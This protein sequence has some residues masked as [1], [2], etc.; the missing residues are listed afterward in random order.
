MELSWRIMCCHGQFSTPNEVTYYS[1]Y[2]WLQKRSRSCIAES[3]NMFWWD[4]YSILITAEYFSVTGSFSNC[5]RTNPNLI[6]FTTKLERPPWNEMP[7]VMEIVIVMEK[8]YFLSGATLFRICAYSRELLLS[9]L[10]HCLSFQ[11]LEPLKQFWHALHHFLSGVCIPV[12]VL[13]VSLKTADGGFVVWHEF[14]HVSSIVEC[15]VSSGGRGGLL[16]GPP[17]GSE[18]GHTGG[19]GWCR[20]VSVCVVTPSW[21]PGGTVPMCVCGRSV[22]RGHLH[23][24]FN[25]IN[26]NYQLNMS[27]HFCDEQKF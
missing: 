14:P 7:C 13:N 26:I 19:S 16:G 22:K 8:N 25:L 4:E 21:H 15:Q 17:V 9:L 5:F 20:V 12:H 18:H 2:C 6:I 1:N 27:F 23:V 11:T 10:D 3:L 24:C